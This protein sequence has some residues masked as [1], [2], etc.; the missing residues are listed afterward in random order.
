LSFSRIDPVQLAVREGLLDEV[1][2]ARA[3]EVQGQQ[4]GASLARLC[5]D[6]GFLDD[7]ALA[8]AL[9]RALNLPRSDVRQI[10]ISPEAFGRV[11]RSVLEAVSAVPFQLK[12]EGKV[13]FIAMADPQDERALL[14]LR[15]V[16]GLQ[17]RVTVAGYGEIA[18]VLAEHAA[19][20]SPNDLERRAQSVRE[21]THPGEAIFDLAA[22]GRE[23]AQLDADPSGAARAGGGPLLSEEERLKALQKTVKQ[24]SKALRAA[25]DLCV[26]KGAFALE[27]IATV[28]KRGSE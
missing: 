16:S 24:S 25:L 28:M 15:E 5:V 18:T 7:A 1:D 14:R 27:D 3:R 8:N 26:E 23:A 9:A 12:Q 6:M 20:E 11:P 22:I 13:L 21:P 2:L 4:G 10:S 17:L 19:K